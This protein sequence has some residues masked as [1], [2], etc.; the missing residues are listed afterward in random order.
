MTTMHAAHAELAQALDLVLE[1]R[2]A[3]DRQDRLG[4][5]LAEG[6]HARALAGGEDHAEHR[7]VGVAHGSTIIPARC[8]FN[9]RRR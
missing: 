6:L 1:Q 5:A 2:L 7:R 8:S 9:L 3:E 4:V